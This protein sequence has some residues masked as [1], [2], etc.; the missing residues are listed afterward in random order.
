[1]WQRRK[2]SRAHL[3]R[4]RFSMTTNQTTHVH[5]HRKAD[6]LYIKR[7]MRRE[8]LWKDENVMRSRLSKQRRE[9]VGEPGR[10]N[11]NEGKS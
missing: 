9:G 11:D 8:S 10:R 3:I 4:N 7:W 2:S 5:A 1:M 6:T